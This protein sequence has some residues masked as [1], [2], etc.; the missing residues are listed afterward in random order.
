MLRIQHI[1]SHCKFLNVSRFLHGSHKSIFQ[2]SMWWVEVRQLVLWC[3][4]LKFTVWKKKKNQTSDNHKYFS[5]LLEYQEVF[6]LD[7]SSFKVWEAALV[8]TS[9]TVFCYNATNVHLFCW[10]QQLITSSYCSFHVILEVTETRMRSRNKL[11]ED[12][13]LGFIFFFSFGTIQVSNY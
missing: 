10:G 3:Y 8:L 2:A 5:G 4:T 11:Y 1:L 6:T 13:Y 9:W 7:L 12:C